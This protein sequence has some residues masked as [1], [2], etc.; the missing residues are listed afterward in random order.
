M[1]FYTRYALKYSC[2]TSMTGRDY[3]TWG[4]DLYS[5]HFPKP[6]QEGLR[7]IVGFDPVFFQ[8]IRAIS[9]VNFWK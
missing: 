4:R 9:Y 7:T 8:F 3:D 2:I 6:G 1:N 5:H